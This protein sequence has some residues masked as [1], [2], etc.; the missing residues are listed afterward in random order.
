MKNLKIILIATFAA[1]ITSTTYGALGE[2]ISTLTGSY[3]ATSTSKARLSYSVYE[4]K[5][6]LML[7]RQFAL[8]NG[9][10]FAVAWQGITHPNLQ[11]TLGEYADGYL[12]ELEKGSGRSGSR[13]QKIV[14][15]EMVVE[16][17][18]HGRLL[19]GRAYLP[20]LL[21]AGISINEIK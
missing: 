11:T 15:D 1:L 20:S 10:V 3:T 5:N 7:L 8:P 19:F 17:W 14:T 4:N 21:P 18:G 12:V 9:I 16:K 6:E 13:Q 2:N